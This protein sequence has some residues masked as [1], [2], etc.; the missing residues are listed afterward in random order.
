M[1][2]KV[3]NEV[4]TELMRAVANHDGIGVTAAQDFVSKFEIVIDFLR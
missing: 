3:G 2:I 4:E 1:R